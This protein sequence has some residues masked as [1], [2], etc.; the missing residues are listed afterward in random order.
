[1]L[2][3]AYVCGS[4]AAV[5][6]AGTNVLLRAANRTESERLEFSLQLIKNLLRKR[7]W[8]AAIVIM[9]VS[10]LLQALGLGFGTLAAIEPLLVLEL[11][12]TLLGAR[13]FLGGR[14]GNKERLAIAAMTAGTIGLIAFLAPSSGHRTSIPWDVWLLAIAATAAPIAILFWLGHQSRVQQRRAALLGVAAGLCFGLAASLVKGMTDQ[15]AT[16]GVG[17]ALGSWQLYAA[18]VAGVLGFW[19]DQNAMNVGCLTASQPGVT[20]ADPYVA[21]VW[22]A[23]VFSET[24]RGGF[25]LIAAIVSALAMSVGAVTLATSLDAGDDESAAAE[26]SGRQGGRA[27]DERVG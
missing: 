18:G 16:G 24:M 8:L 5:A 12:L 21:I 4:L 13:L 15:F 6:N 19:F 7:R 22:G 25:W 2:I 23:L 20:L 27:A 1:M 17:G 10:F 3:L 14:L 9:I 26:D 11:P